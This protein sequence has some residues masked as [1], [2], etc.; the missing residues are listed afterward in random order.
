MST[1]RHTLFLAFVVILFVAIVRWRCK[2]LEVSKCPFWREISCSSVGPILATRSRR[3]RDSKT[4]NHGFANPSQLSKMFV[5]AIVWWSWNQS[6]ALR[7]REQKSERCTPLTSENHLFYDKSFTRR[8]SV[9]SIPAIEVHQHGN[10]CH[11]RY[12]TISST[13][14]KQKSGWKS[15]IFKISLWHE[16][17]FHRSI[18]QKQTISSCNKMMVFEWMSSFSVL[19]IVTFSQNCYKRIY[20]TVESLPEMALNDGSST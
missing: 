9:K 6:K 10:V 15:F 4:R 18:H 11:E 2:Q 3:D 19:K 13:L 5:A 20:F 7:S 12:P 14:R 1:V 16:V 17:N 8:D